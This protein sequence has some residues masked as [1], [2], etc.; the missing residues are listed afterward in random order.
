M[1]VV[2]PRTLDWSNCS[3]KW[4]SRLEVFYASERTRDYL[5]LADEQL[6][7]ITAICYLRLM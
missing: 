6:K 2:P 1:H 7:K 3:V 5:T 4:R